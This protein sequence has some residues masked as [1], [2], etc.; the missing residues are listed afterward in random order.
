MG[1]LILNGFTAAIDRCYQHFLLVHKEIAASR[2]ALLL[3]SNIGGLLI[4]LALPGLWRDEWP[5]MKERMHSWHQGEGWSDLNLVMLSCIG[6]LSIGYTG[7]GFQKTVSASSFL[8]VATGVRALLLLVDNQV[9]GT[10]LQALASLGLAIVI[11][12]SVI[13][14]NDQNSKK[15]KSAQE[16]RRNSNTRRDSWSNQ[17]SG[18]APAG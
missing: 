4:I 18:P 1:V 9:L 14:V 10:R 6:G 13:C 16:E 5:A 12:G 15:T 8:A 2:G 7:L 3:T 17:N 11:A